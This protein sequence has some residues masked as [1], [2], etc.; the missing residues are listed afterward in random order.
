[1]EEG[2]GLVSR[3]RNHVIN[4]YPRSNYPTHRMNS[5]HTLRLLDLQRR[6]CIISFSVRGFKSRNLIVF[7]YCPETSQYYPENPESNCFQGRQE[8]QMALSG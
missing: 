6:T 7:S 8:K 5:S 2:K 4:F 1:M 3:L